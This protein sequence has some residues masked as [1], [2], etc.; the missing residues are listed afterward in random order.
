MSQPT[1]MSHAKRFESAVATH[2]RIASPISILANPKDFSA[3]LRELKMDSA[4]GLFVERLA[5][6]MSRFAAQERVLLERY[7]DGTAR[8]PET[9]NAFVRFLF[10][11]GLQD[12]VG[13]KLVLKTPLGDPMVEHC[14]FAVKSM[15]S[16]RRFPDEVNLFG[17]GL[18]DGSWE[19][20]LGE[21]LVHRGEAGDVSLL[22]YDPF[23][24]RSPGIKYLDPK[25]IGGR[26]SPGFDLV[27]ARWALHH[28]FPEQR[29][30]MFARILS[31]LNPGGIALVV[32]HGFMERPAMPRHEHLYRLLNAVLD[33]IANLGFRP[34]WFAATKPE[35]G[36]DFYVD[37]LRAQDIDAIR[38]KCSRP[39]DVDVVS[40]GPNFPW[41][42]IIAF[43]PRASARRR[44]ISRA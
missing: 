12:R 26:R 3:L 41:H 5:P 33:V 38:S 44:P 23:A 40:A 37:F 1:V 20:K 39:L 29:W 27:L 17:F 24:V 25:R 42:S 30:D 13:L 22:G 32:E 36:R 18:G 9:A 43:K 10:R 21:F 11:Q 19:R 4:D 14:E 31:Q 2:G 34:E 8:L 35:F 15:L 16:G 7:F 6:I 28:V